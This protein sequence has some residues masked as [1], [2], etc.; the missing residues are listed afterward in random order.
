MSQLKFL[1]LVFV[2]FCENKLKLNLLKCMCFYMC[3][4]VKNSNT[5]INNNLLVHSLNCKKNLNNK[6]SV[7]IY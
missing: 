5:L 4:E 3:F 2:W 1:N 7:G 6:S